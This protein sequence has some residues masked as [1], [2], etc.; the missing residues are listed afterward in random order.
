MIWEIHE[1]RLFQHGIEKS[2]GF[3]TKFRC[4][5]SDVRVFLFSFP[6]SSRRA[7]N[8]RIN[9]NVQKCR[10]EYHVDEQSTHL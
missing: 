1:C 4:I 5:D 7:Q 10:I 6:A 9:K 2:M 8:S 3:F